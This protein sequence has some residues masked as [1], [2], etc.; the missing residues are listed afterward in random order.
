MERFYEIDP[1]I[2]RYKKKYKFFQRGVPRV[3]LDHLRSFEVLAAL[4]HYG[5]AAEQLHVSQP[6]LTY[7]IS[8]MEQELGVPL[9]EKTGRNIR[10]TR[11]GQQFLR[12]VHSSLNTLDTGIRTV[13][14]LG[15]GGGLVLLGSIRK[16][17]TMLVP[18]LMRDFRAQID[19]AVQFQ[20]HS[21]SGFSA[22]LLKAVEEGRLDLA[23]TSHPGDPVQF[24]SFAFQRTPFVV[25]TPMGHPL[26]RK[27]SVSLR[28]TLPY[29]QICFAPRSGLRKSV[30]ALF[31][32]I[33]AAPIVAMETEEDAVIAGLVAAGF[34]IAVL[35]DDPLFQSLPLAVLPLTE[36]DPARTAYLSR[37]RGTPLPN[38]A[39]QFWA[40]CQEKL[41]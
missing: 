16:L 32:S 3:N 7:A 12:T 5:K 40:F 24:E 22:D 4:Q 18:G 29:P 19:P 13:Q 38:A 21:E 26:A 25:I 28:D 11:Y 41:A 15:Q 37:R 33:D 8:Q 35:P 36:P 31:C 14:E 9:F 1:K 17:G 23:F 2:L 27:T 6:S 34:G 39:E 20:L 30:D 10:L